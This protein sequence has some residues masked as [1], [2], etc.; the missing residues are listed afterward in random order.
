MTISEYENEIIKLKKRILFLEQERKIGIIS[1]A[2]KT[3]STPPP[4]T[5]IFNKAK[6]LVG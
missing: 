2:K 4:F 3:V 6:E 5:E 1:K